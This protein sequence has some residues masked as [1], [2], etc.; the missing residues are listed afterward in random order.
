MMDLDCDRNRKQKRKRFHIC[1]FMLQN[2][3]ASYVKY[4][5]KH[6]KH[7]SNTHIARKCYFHHMVKE[8]FLIFESQQWKVN[9]N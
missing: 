2:C 9:N 4:G 5:M 3:K 1:N 6:A 7:L 8:T